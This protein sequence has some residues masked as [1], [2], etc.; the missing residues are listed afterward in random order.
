MSYAHSVVKV[1]GLIRRGALLFVLLVGVSL[2]AA[3]AAAQNRVI[4]KQT[5]VKEVDKSWKVAIE[6]HLDRA[7]DVA[8]MPVRFS[9]TPVSYFERALVDGKSE[10]VTRQIA[11]SNQQPIVESVDVG[12]LDPGTGKAAKRTRFSF[13][14]TR[15]RGFEAGIYEVIVTDARSDREF[16]GTTTL[17][18]DGENDVIDRR[19]MVFED[20]PKAKKDSAATKAQSEERELSPDDEAYW[21]GG[22]KEPEEKRAPLPPPAHMQERPGCGCRIQG[23]TTVA[24]GWGLAALALGL[25]VRRRRP[26]SPLP[27]H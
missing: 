21:A 20:K 7:P 5:K 12:F 6:V 9:F 8:H 11:L 3:P 22:P 27:L 15:D 10:P 1:S 24:P 25:L 18:L 4:W 19:S 16:G 13:H 17:T 2:F 14:V 23:P 26:S